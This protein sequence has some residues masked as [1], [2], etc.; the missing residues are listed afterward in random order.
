MFERRDGGAGGEHP[1]AKQIDRRL[2]IFAFDDFDE[3]RGFG[4]L[5]GSAFAAGPNDN[6]ERP[7]RHGL[8]H[9]G[10]EGAHPTR[11]FVQGLQNADSA[12]HG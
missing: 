9:G 6:G 12:R 10:F 7:E 3:G 1:A 4:R 11:D 5:F 2:R 8:A